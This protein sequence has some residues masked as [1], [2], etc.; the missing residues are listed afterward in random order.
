MP[1]QGYRPEEDISEDD[2][3]PEEMKIAIAA[4]SAAL[5]LFYS[6]DWHAKSLCAAIL[7]VLKERA[8]KA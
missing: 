5:P 1:C 7:A 4:Y 8:L 3:T 2:L 6:P